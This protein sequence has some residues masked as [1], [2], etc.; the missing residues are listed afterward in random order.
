MNIGQAAKASGVSAKMIR[1]YETTGLIAKAYRTDAGYRNYEDQDVHT[2][3]FIR[4]ARD[5]GFTVEQ[6]GGLLTL[7]QDRSRASADVKALALSHIAELKAKI[8][9]LEAM[10]RTLEHLADHC[11]GDDRPECPI[12]EDLAHKSGAFAGDGKHRPAPRFGEAG[13]R[14]AARQ[15]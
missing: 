14:P 8:I 5:L 4:R 1:Y 12:I 11:V 2:L 15:I 6:I 9:E 3:R 13:G 10:T 7:W